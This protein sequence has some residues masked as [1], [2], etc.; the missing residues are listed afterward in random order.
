M[1]VKLREIK[2]TTVKALYVL[3]LMVVLV[4]IDSFTTG[5]LADIFQRLLP[6]PEAAPTYHLLQ[7]YIPDY[8][9]L[10]HEQLEVYYEE[11]ESYYHSFDETNPSSKELDIR[12]V[13][14]E[15]TDVIFILQGLMTELYHY[16][17]GRSLCF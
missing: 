14:D 17:T 4:G 10:T 12:I 6:Q 8:E 2:E 9:E 16:L 3:T 1:N 5:T 11:L 13:V 7:Q 15:N